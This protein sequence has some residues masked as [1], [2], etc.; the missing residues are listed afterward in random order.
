MMDVLTVQFI[1]TRS[2]TGGYFAE[3]PELGARV[4]GST[5]AVL[6]TRLMEFAAWLLDEPGALHSGQTVL[7][8]RAGAGV[9]LTRHSATAFLLSPSV[10][11][12]PGTEVLRCDGSHGVSSKMG[13]GRRRR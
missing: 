3:C 11:K 12:R 1:V 10:G 2:A 13:S 5:L 8:G 9:A 4:N 6:E 7:S